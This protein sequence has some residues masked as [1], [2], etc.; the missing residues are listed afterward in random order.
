MENRVHL[1][2][3]TA[4]GT[5]YENHVHA[6]TLPLSG[7]ACGIL[8]GHAPLM[9]AVIDGV[10][11]CTFGE[12]EQAYIAVG[13]GVANVV[14]DEVTLLVRTAEP[15]EE[16]DLHRAEDSEQRARAR[17]VQKAADLDAARAEASLRRALA[18]QKAAR[19]AKK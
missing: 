17:L 6:V 19:L 2:I 8:A 10:V 4:E 15:A 16:I 3:V 14:R 13:L 12:D 18:R 5:K 11:H 7:G 9:G 1:Q